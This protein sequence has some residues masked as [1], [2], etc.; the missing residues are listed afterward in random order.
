MHKSGNQWG[1]LPVLC[2]G[3]LCVLMAQSGAAAAHDSSRVKRILVLGDSLSEGYMLRSS[4]AWPMLLV[5][6]LRA[7]GLEFQVTNASQSGGTTAGGLARLPPHL[8]HPIDIFVLEL[9]I[10]D[11]F[12]GIAIDQIENNLQ[13]IIHRVRAVSPGVRI[14]IAG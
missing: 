4:E 13:A 6:K 3:G 9:G 11:A 12:R 14:V 7:A 1:T 10:N 8:K 2:V 5:D